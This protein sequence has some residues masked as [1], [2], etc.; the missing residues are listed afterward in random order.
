MKEIDI[1][2]KMRES[3]SEYTGFDGKKMFLRSWVP[4]GEPRAVMIGIHGLG[5]HSGLLKFVAEYFANNGMRFYAPDL[6]GFGH[7]DGI[8]GH[9]ERFDDYIED[10]H[11]L[12]TRVKQENPN[13]KIFL[14]GHSYAGLII[15]LYAVK[16]QTHVDGLITPC[17]SVSERLA[18]SSVTRMLMK[19]LSRL[20]IKKQ[21]DNG[22]DIDLIARNPEVVRRNKED[23][24]RFDVVTP[25]LGAEGLKAIQTAFALAPS[26]EIPIFMQQTGDDLILIPERNKEFFDVIG[27]EDKTWKLYEG[28]YHEPFEDEGGMI[29][30]TDIIDW[31]NAHI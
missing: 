14:Y 13:K 30:L 20:N 19:L 12:V 11:S 27:S 5:S 3:E 10:L 24:L 9:V 23:P 18:I 28:L 21:F 15:P 7:F 2:I 29:V 16:Y 6:R 25:R 8:K 26:I 31:M 17:P 22:L 1:G 4:D